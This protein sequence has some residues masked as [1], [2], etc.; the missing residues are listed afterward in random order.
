MTATR[1]PRSRGTRITLW[2]IGG[3]ALLVVLAAAW[4]GVRGLLA[5]RDL[6]SAKT[7]VGSIRSEVIGTQDLAAAR[8]DAATLTTKADAAHSLTSDPIWRAAEIVPG[9]GPN[10]RATREVS[11]AVAQVADGAVSPL[12]ALSSK[13]SPSEFKPVDGAIPLQPLIDAQPAAAAA[14]TAIAQASA[15]LGA[16]D[17]AGTVAPLHDAVTS[18]DSQLQAA[19]SE[20]SALDYAVKLLPTML[21]ENGPRHYLLAFLNNAELRSLGGINGADA[22]V[23]VDHGKISLTKQATDTQL[24]FFGT[25]AVTMDQNSIDLYTQNPAMYSQDPPTLPRFPMAAEQL[26]A[27][28]TQRFGGTIDGVVSIDPVA[29]GYLLPATGPITLPDGQQLTAQNAVQLLL[30]EVYSKYPDPDAQNTFFAETAAAV[31]TKIAGGSFSP[32]QLLTGL[33]RAGDEHRINI[34]STDAAEQKLLATT[35][36]AGGLPASTATT[37]T[38]G[39]YLNDATGAKMDY[40]LRVSAGAAA[41]WCGAGQGTHYAVTM[42]L[43]SQAPANAA[44]SLNA[45]ITGGD[46]LGTPAGQ[47]WTDVTVYAPKGVTLTGYATAAKDLTVSRFPDNGLSTGQFRS[48]LHPGSSQTVTLYFNG[49]K[50]VPA[51]AV[52]TTPMVATVSPA[53]AEAGCAAP[54]TPAATPSE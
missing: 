9:L 26:R 3:L 36:L 39:A 53:T 1:S 14:T 17:T 8:A 19:S 18:L 28:W 25:M 41:V 22:L 2:S 54:A 32:T 42:T 48:M 31:F 11:A 50:R 15:S 20:V 7:L 23:T 21:G 51:A 13:I 4:I 27:M 40:Y 12:I 37:S 44:T 29:L 35:T 16:I 43:S 33:A 34:W 47:T 24:G 49:P 45:T 10:L 6:E 46:L 30:S 5:Y 52:E 38:F